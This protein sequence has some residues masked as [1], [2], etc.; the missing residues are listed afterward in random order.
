MDLDSGPLFLTF[1]DLIGPL[2]K[3]LIVQINQ[4]WNNSF[5][6]TVLPFFRESNFWLPLYLF[7]VLFMTMNFRKQGW[8]WVLGFA[9]AIVFADLVSSQLIKQLIFRLRP[10]QDPTIAHQLRFFISYCPKSS[11]FTSS[12][13]TS[14]FAQASFIYW[15]WKPIWR[16]RGVFFI[17]AALIAYTQVYVGVHYP[18]D[19][20]CGSLVG[21]L[22]GRLLTKIFHN[23]AGMLSL[24]N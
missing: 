18:F 8:W 15:T 11:S 10:C 4:H 2:D 20:V 21:L 9:L 1:W 23:R 12:H 17:W 7:L 3:W 19:V 14:F 22:L 6:D 5:F 13:A 16:H 24:V